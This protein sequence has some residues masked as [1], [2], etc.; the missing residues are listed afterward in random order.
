V[1]PE[2]SFDALDGEVF[3]L[4][5]LS[6]KSTFWKIAWRDKV[7]E[8]NNS[9]C[10]GCGS[11]DHVVALPIVP[12]EVGGSKS[13]DN[14]VLVCRVCRL[15][16]AAHYGGR[17]QIPRRSLSIYL[18]RELHSRMLEVIDHAEFGFSSVSNLIRGMI[19]EAL[20]DLSKLSDFRVQERKPADVKI[21]ATVYIEDFER[22]KKALECWPD[23][24]VID[25]VQGMIEHHVDACN[26]RLVK[27]EV[28]NA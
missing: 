15:V 9:R 17:E 11:E 13:V 24:T 10:N 3:N 22:L 7:F 25:V 19:E 5:D 20:K 18:P 12:F 6:F 16:S 1:E 28:K 23:V 14:G 8:K 21:V 27:K 4:P 2:I 26:S